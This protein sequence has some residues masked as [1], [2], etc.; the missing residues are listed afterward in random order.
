MAA[1]E[2]ASGPSCTSSPAAQ[3][4][5]L[6]SL[7][8]ATTESALESGRFA[9]CCQPLV[10]A[11]SQLSGCFECRKKSRPPIPR[12]LGS[13]GRTHPFSARQ[14]SEG[15]PTNPKLLK[16]KKVPLPRQVQ[17]MRS[18]RRRKGQLGAFRAFVR[19]KTLGQQGRPDLRRIG[20]MYRTA[21]EEGHRDV[22]RAQ[23]LSNAVNLLKRVSSQSQVGQ[24]RWLLKSKYVSKQRQKQALSAFLSTHAGTDHPGPGLGTGASEPV[25]DHHH[26]ASSPRRGV[27]LELSEPRRSSASSRRSKP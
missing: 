2:F 25:M 18:Q 11:P 21:K 12:R 8:W 10:K 6:R 24:Q 3:R 15:A 22:D 16:Y 19:L 4:T 5:G 9:N 7:S 14:K 27:S 17:K 1:P 23:A 26:R 13:Q 20:V